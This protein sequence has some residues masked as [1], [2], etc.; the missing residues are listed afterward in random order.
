[1]RRRYRGG[2]SITA[3]VLAAL[4]VVGGVA[5]TAFADVRVCAVSS[6][7]GALT[8]GE[9]TSLDAQEARAGELLDISSGAESTAGA[10][11]KAILWGFLAYAVVMV[12]G[13]GASN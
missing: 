8:E 13:G 2:V 6:T 9:A 3:T 4:M 12:L 10:I 11:G 5:Q 7:A 1:M